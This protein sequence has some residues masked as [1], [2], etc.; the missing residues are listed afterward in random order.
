MA[1]DS[2]TGTAVAEGTGTWTW[3]GGADA[4]VDVDDDDDELLFG[5]LLA[6]SYKYRAERY[7]Y[8]N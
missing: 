4:R 3:A 1:D 5:D 7:P 8:G 2:H 6:T